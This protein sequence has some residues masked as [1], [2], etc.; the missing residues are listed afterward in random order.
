[1]EIPLIDHTEEF[2][3]GTEMLAAEF[4][5]MVISLSIS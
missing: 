4:F 2:L 5:P 1:M 3:V